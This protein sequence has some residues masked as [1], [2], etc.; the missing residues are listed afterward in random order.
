MYLTLFSLVT[1]SCDNY[2]LCV[3]QIRSTDWNS[4]QK[5]TEI[6]FESQIFHFKRDVPRLVPKLVNICKTFAFTGGK[7]KLYSVDFK[8]PLNL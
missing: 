4:H 7:N 1:I 8:I 3:I 6:H 2:F 5:E